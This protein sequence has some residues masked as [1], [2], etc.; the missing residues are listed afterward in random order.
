MKRKHGEGRRYALDIIT[1]EDLEQFRGMSSELEALT[2]ERTWLYY[3]VSS[4]NG[5]ENI[6]QRGNTPS[7][8]TASAYHKIEAMDK[9]IERAREEII[10]KQNAILDWLE[11]VSDREVRA[12]IHWHYIR[13]LNWKQTSRKVYGYSDYQVARKRVMRFFGREK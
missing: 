9:R 6:G 2:E 8:P 10:E 12:M 3:P 5:R 4:P 13:G 7:D 11:T 1:I